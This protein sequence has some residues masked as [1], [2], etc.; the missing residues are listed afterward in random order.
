[1]SSNPASISVKPVGYFVWL[2]TMTGI[3]VCEKV[4]REILESMQP[5][6][7]K[8]YDAKVVARFPLTEAEWTLSLDELA[9]KYPASG[10]Q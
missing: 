3:A 9:T 2:K 6:T 7:K 5:P 10:R 8:N 1:M 4:D